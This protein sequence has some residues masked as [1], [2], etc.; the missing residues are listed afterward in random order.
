MREHTDADEVAAT[1]QRL[2]A[3]RRAHDLD[4]AT[5]TPE[6]RWRQLYEIAAEGLPVL[7]TVGEA[8]NWANSYLDEIRGRLMN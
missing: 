6:E 5:V 7:R 1:T 8:A 2:F 4:T 3:F